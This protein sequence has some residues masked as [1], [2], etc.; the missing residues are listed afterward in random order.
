MQ[1]A[2]RNGKQYSIRH[3]GTTSIRKDNIRYGAGGD[4]QCSDEGAGLLYDM[5]MKYVS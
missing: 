2:E 5:G 1:F 4:F 3:R